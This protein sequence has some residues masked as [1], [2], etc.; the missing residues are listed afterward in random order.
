[1]SEIDLSQQSIELLSRRIV[2]LMRNEPRRT[3]EIMTRAEMKAFLRC[4]SEGA[5]VAYC[6]R[7]KIKPVGHGRWSRAQAELAIG[8]EAGIE[9]TPLTLRRHQE[10]IKVRVR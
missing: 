6:R 3:P 2:E 10:A 8:R 4:E 7:W 1:M 5:F 9:H